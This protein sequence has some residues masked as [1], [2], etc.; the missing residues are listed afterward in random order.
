MK[1]L[2]DR[3]PSTGTVGI[4]ALRSAAAMLVLAAG[5]CSALAQN[6]SNGAPTYRS[7]PASV[8]RSGVNRSGQVSVDDNLTVELHVRDEDL[9]N[10]LQLL[11]LQSQKSIIAGPNVNA[12]VTADLYGATFYEALDAILHSYGY[13]YLEQGNFI[14]VMTQEEIEQIA[15]Q[16]RIPV[17][18]IIT[19]NYLAAVD[20]AEYVSPLLSDVG[21]IRTNGRTTEYS[22]GEDNPD[23]QD[24][25][26]GP[27][28]MIVFDYEEH[29]TEI[30]ALVQQID[31]RPQQVLVEATV[32][33]AQLREQNA[34]GVD[35]SLVGDL[36]FSEFVG[37][38]LGAANN[39]I[40]GIAPS[41]GEGR[42]VVGS[43]GQTSQAGG[44]KIGIVD[45]D[46]AVF[47]RFLDEVTD[48]TVLSNPKIVALNRQQGRVQVGRRIGYLQVTTTD[49]ST[50]QSVEFLDT[51]TQLSFRPFIM[52]NRQ[53][54]ME[55]RP[56]VSRP[57]L[58]TV[59]D[60]NGNPVTIPDEDTSELVT[61]VIVNDGQ[62]IV[63]GG[64]FTES[65][66]SSRRQVPFFGDLPILGIPFRG[67][68]DTIDRAEVIFLIKSTIMSD[69][70]LIEQ[71]R[72][73]MA[74]VDRVRIGAREG[75]LPWSRERQAGQLI[76][77]AERLAA[78][79]DMNGAL[80]CVRRALA[81]Q[82]M[83][84][85]AIRLRERLLSEPTVWPSRSMNEDIF[86][87]DVDNRIRSARDQ[88]MAE[89]TSL[90]RP[91][92][93]WDNLNAIP[94]QE[95]AGVNTDSFD[96]FDS[97]AGSGTTPNDSFEDVD[98]SQ[99]EYELEDP[100]S[101]AFNSNTDGSTNTSGNSDSWTE[102]V[103]NES[104]ANQATSTPSTTTNTTSPTSPNQTQAPTTQAQ[105]GSASAA[106]TNT[107]GSSTQ[108]QSQNGQMFPF[109]QAPGTTANTLPSVEPDADGFYPIAPAPAT[110]TT[111]ASVQQISASNPN[112]VNLSAPFPSTSIYGRLAWIFGA[113]A[114][115]QNAEQAAPQT[116]TFATVP[117][118][119]N[120][121]NP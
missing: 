20:A 44:L 22:V 51:G 23:G 94:R 67:H 90:I 110:N 73:G 49:T 41:D 27:S 47:M 5:T 95:F 120:S 34:F 14:Y 72:R 112:N 56:E 60:T 99:L 35:F 111:T 6:S 117:E 121:E 85:D 52:N 87:S 100:E 92:N 70:S 101:G 91:D 37:G 115:E 77:R 89:F 103:S 64:L 108:G 113:R 54:R 13:G 38:P 116:G 24:D 118:S 109:V 40:N 107:A 80:H 10:V 25:Y 63:L 69:E 61:N 57:F 97:N 75:L 83:Q 71:G 53:I 65:T 50:Q 2:N 16:S 30:E 39:L 74:Y 58:R 55:L 29:I 3:T 82:P 33:Q 7:R 114:A 4:A 18:K 45:N 62:T 31:T 88:A 66:V 104:A 19:L 76:V 102:R 81:L 43:V 12:V 26:A 68:D 98:W 119:T 79:G 96:S 8:D 105:A 78:E 21:E 48:T 17:V 15:A 28:M 59:T 86:N 36:D 46:V 42:A 11:S 106:P 32:L 9:A 84:P 1:T 93:R